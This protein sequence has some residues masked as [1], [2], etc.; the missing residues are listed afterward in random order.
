[1]ERIV[2][3]IYRKDRS[4]GEISQLGYGCMRFTKKGTAIDFDKAESEILHAVEGGVNYFDTAY[5]YPGS[6]ECLGRII[7]KNGLRDK[8]K[9]AI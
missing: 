5:I 9:I 7:E 6:E 4:G 1:M 8:I 2:L 3:V